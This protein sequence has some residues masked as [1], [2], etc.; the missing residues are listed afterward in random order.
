VYNILIALGISL[1]A[2][3]VG[4]LGGRWYYGFMPAILM[5]PPAMFLLSRRTGKQLEAVMKQVQE[6]LMRQDVRGAREILEGGL[7]LGKWQLLVAEQIYAQLGALEFVQRNYKAARPLLEKAWKRNW[8][9]QGMLALLDARDGEHAAGVARLE[10]A[11]FLGKRD[12]LMWALLIHLQ[13]EQSDTDGALAS[14]GEALKVLPE[15]KALKELQ[16]AI[17]N[18]RVKKFK[19]DKQFGD[20]WLQFFPEEAYQRAVRANKQQLIQARRGM[21]A[22]PPRR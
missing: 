9:A 6:R 1:L 13:L 11:K 17:A 4:A 2:F 18:D 21:G 14:A 19:W 8:Q 12:P 15:S 20:A 16:G 22:P 7:P 10:K 5:F 3:G